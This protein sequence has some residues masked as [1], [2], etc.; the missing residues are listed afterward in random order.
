M[1]KFLLVT[2]AVSVL[3]FALVANATTFTYSVPEF[4]G[5]S[6]IPDPGPFPAYTVAALAFPTSYNYQDVSVSGTFGNSVFPNSSGVDVFF[7]NITA[8]FFLVGQ[9][10]EFDPCS[11]QPD[12]NSMGYHLGPLYLPAGTYYLIASQTSQYVVQLGIT[13]INASV[14]EPSSLLLLGTGLLGAVGAVR[15]KFI[16]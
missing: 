13:T 15:R 9:C 3:G 4:T 2:L 5:T 12:T 11:F 14:P 16:G 1:K 10:F 7:G 8:G 6:N